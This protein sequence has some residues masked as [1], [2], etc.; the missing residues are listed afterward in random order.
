MSFAISFP[1]F[2]SDPNENGLMSRL[3]LT[4]RR[5]MRR[6][7]GLKFSREDTARRR[8]K[9]LRCFHLLAFRLFA[10]SRE[11][12]KASI[13]SSEISNLETTVRSRPSC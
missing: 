5:A 8:Q 9:P 2:L 7:L 10:L 3:V 4:G 6:C 11:A 12:V 1:V 13:R